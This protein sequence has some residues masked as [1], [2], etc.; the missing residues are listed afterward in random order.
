LTEEQIQPYGAEA[1]GFV[2]LMK[3]GKFETLEEIKV[4]QRYACFWNDFLNSYEEDYGRYYRVSTKGKNA[5][6]FRP[7]YEQLLNRNLVDFDSDK[8]RLLKHIIRHVAIGGKLPSGIPVREAITHEERGRQALTDGRPELYMC[9]FCKTRYSTDG[10]L[11]EHL[12][13]FHTIGESK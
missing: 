4:M 8:K 2:A 7:T 1:K 9:P 5:V 11:K 12:L 13:T 3:T 6:F 10:E